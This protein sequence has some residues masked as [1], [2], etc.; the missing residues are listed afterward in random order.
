MDKSVIICLI[1][2]KADDKLVYAIKKAALNRLVVSSKKRIDNKYKKFE[3]L[4]SAFIHRSCQSQY[5]D[6]TAIATF[7]SSRYKKAKE[8][9]EV[10]KDALGFNFESHC[11]ICGGFF[12]NISKEKISCVQGN[13]T[14]DNILQYIHKQHTLND[15]DK[16]ISARLHNVP[17]LLAVKAHYHTACMATFYNKRTEK[18]RGR[19]ACENTKNFINYLINYIVDNGAECQFS[20]NEIK[21]GFSGDLPDYT[22]IKNKLKE[23]FQNDIECHLIKR[24]MIILYKNGTASKKLYKDWYEKRLKSKEDERTRIVEMAA[25]IVLE[26][27]RS[28]VYDMNYYETLDID[29]GN[30]FKDVPKTLQVFL[31]VVCKSNKEKS[32]NNVRRM[33]KKVA[34]M[35]HCIITSVE[36][37]SFLSPILLGLSSMIHK[38]YASKG[39]IDSLSNLG[40]CSSYKDTLR[41]EASIIKDPA[42]HIVSPDSYVQFVFDNAD[43]NTCT[44]DGKNTFHAMGGITVVTPASSVTSKKSI[45]RLKQI[46]SSEEIGETG[47]VKLK[48]FEN[49]N[50]DGLKTVQIE[51]VLDV[52]DNYEISSADF[53]WTYSKFA[54]NKSDGWNGFMEKLHTN[55]TYHV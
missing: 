48:H 31:N 29:E 1:C 3:T 19:S 45:S 22:T 39:L 43:H 5:N 32:K 7:C 42:N 8:G 49:K 14:R 16:K 47:F 18:K 13:D 26:D 17:D 55:L 40:L 11:F 24:D 25:E 50:S 9:K 27:I 23:H 41:F 46:P 54:N 15:F 53:T 20:V 35:S 2:N 10:I 36:P 37:R 38:K 34:T 33:D 44:I 28:K 6:D 12:G 52:T 30:L 51:D 4:T 21:E